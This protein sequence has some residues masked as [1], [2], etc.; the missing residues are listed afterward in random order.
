MV[1]LPIERT[2]VRFHLRRF[3]AGAISFTPLCPC[4]SE[5]RLKGP[6]VQT[7]ALAQDWA[8]WSIIT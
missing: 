7:P 4:L 3:E 1:N 8:V 2:V 6:L 5:E